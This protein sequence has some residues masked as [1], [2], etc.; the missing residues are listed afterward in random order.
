[1][2]QGRSRPVRRTGAVRRGLSGLVAAVV[3]LL[4]APGVAIAHARLESADPA[5]GSVLS[6]AP[7][8]VTLTF[9]EPVEVSDG[10]VL[11]Y[12]DRY[13]RV[14]TGHVT[15]LT[16][17]SGSSDRRLRTGLRPG[18]RDGTYVVIWHASSAD[19]HPVTGTFRFSIGAPSPVRGSAPDTGHN[20]AAGALMGPLRWLGY[21]GL[22]LAPGVLVM[23]LWLWPEGMT[24]RR[25]RRLLVGGLVVLAVG[26]VGGMLLQGVYASGR[27]ISAVWSDPASLD[28]HSH[29]FDTV[30][31]VRSYLLVLLAGVITAAVRG[32]GA[33]GTGRRVLRTGAVALT[34]LTAA[35]WPVAGHSAAAPRA[36]LTVAVNLAHTLAMVVWLGGL[37]GIL[38]GLGLPE[39]RPALAR[40]LPHFSRVA[41]TSV[42][43]LV[44]TGT[45][46]AWTEVSSVGA[47][48]PTTYGRVLMA[49]LAGVAG[50]VVLGNLARRWLLRHRLP[51]GDGETEQTT[52]EPADLGSRTLRAGLA[53]ETALAAGVLGL[54]SALVV[55]VPARA[56]FVEPWRTTVSTGGAIV[57]VEV[58]TPRVGDTVARIRLSSPDGTAR[59]I[60][61]ASGSVSRPGTRPD[62]SPVRLPVVASSADGAAA[63]EVG[64]TFEGPGPWLIRLT[65]TAG[66]GAP[67]AVSF[68]VPI[69]SD[70]S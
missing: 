62:P 42:A 9:G 22:V 15:G 70:A 43:A 53:G 57:S 65:L 64:L 54:T 25:V 27:P 59:P 38:A 55:I 61:A 34:V 36:G 56:D 35:T 51:T 69:V 23:L 63:S 39:H 24:T 18:L 4:T 28:T 30:Y 2:E 17:P 66:G 60:S 45:Y 33:A 11:V 49:K 13:E 5:A 48:T 40:A 32:L 44:V 41:L 31:A 52:L 29:T 6:T 10:A 37:V 58:P 26:T 12:D 7:A 19:T 1:M 14:D 47:I 46:L 16:T 21:A 68:T 8:A 50:L 67:T 20:D 3:L